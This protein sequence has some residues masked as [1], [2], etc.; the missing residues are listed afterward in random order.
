MKEAIMSRELVTEHELLSHVVRA[1]NANPVTAGWIPTGLHEHEEDAEGCNWNIS[2]MH[3]DRSDADVRDVAMVEGA[4]I[5][6]G[7]RARYNLL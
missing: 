6:N 7:L 4:E 3:R 5:I 2:H 1:F